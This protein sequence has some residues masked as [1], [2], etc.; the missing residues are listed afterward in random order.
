MP[1][2]AAAA[3]SAGC[4]S[5][6]GCS[7]WSAWPVPPARSAI[8][9]PGDRS[10]TPAAYGTAPR[11]TAWSVSLA[12]R[13]R[14]PWYDFVYG[15]QGGEQFS[16]RLNATD[17]A[18]LGHGVWLRIKTPTLPTT[19]SGVFFDLYNQPAG[20]CTTS[21]Y[22]AWGWLA[23][24]RFSRQHSNIEQDFLLCATGVALGS[25][26]FIVASFLKAPLTGN[27]I[28]AARQWVSIASQVKSNSSFL[29]TCDPASIA[30][31][32]A[33]HSRLL[34]HFSILNFSLRREVLCW[35]VVYYL[36]SN[37][38]ILFAMVL[39]AFT[40]RTAAQ[41]MPQTNFYSILTAFV[42]ALI[43][44]W[45]PPER[46]FYFFMNFINYCIPYRP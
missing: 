25:H 17:E 6:A 24:G 42:M 12:T 36:S 2:A 26:H 11:A 38:E 10:P 35:M 1:T 3:F 20:D 30:I 40:I 15:W 22:F 9:W 27:S 7:F 5:P 45:R 41:L 19:A 14:Y 8:A 4:R 39:P 37:A 21:L 13:S 23:T 16:K 44:N 18:P 43:T 34:I 46:F 31:S 29:I 28:F 33:I 32:V